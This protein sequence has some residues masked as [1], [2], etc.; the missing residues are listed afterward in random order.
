MIADT[1]RRRSNVLFLLGV[2]E[3]LYSLEV[4]A[5]AVCI[6]MANRSI[7]SKIQWSLLDQLS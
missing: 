2:T 7:L 4:A 6:R 1:E 3:T 5:V